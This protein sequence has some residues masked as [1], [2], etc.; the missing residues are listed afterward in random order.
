MVMVTTADEEINMFK[1]VKRSDS[2]EANF[3]RM[4]WTDGDENGD[5]SNN[6]HSEE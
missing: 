6:R 3:S 1:N 4:Q 5:D 2:L